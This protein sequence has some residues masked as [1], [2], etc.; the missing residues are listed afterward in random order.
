MR[1][2]LR[3]LRCGERAAHFSTV[4]AKLIC[5]NFDSL[6]DSVA[7]K[8]VPN[9]VANSTFATGFHS[10]A[11]VSTNVLDLAQKFAPCIVRCAVDALSN[12]L[13]HCKRLDLL[14]HFVDSFATQAVKILNP[15]IEVDCT[16]I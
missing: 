2:I 8:I 6:S 1:S 15:E 11:V 14:S 9:C 12:A 5:I 7:T 16:T 4:A 10:T 13:T 3:Q